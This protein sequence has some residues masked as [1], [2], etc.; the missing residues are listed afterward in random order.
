MNPETNELLQE[1]RESEELYARAFMTNPVAMSITAADSGRFTHI[2]SAFAE[3]VGFLRIEIIG[4]TSEE[5]GFWPDR[6]N[7]EDV[8]IRVEE[9]DTYPLIPAKVRRKDG[10]DISVLVSFRHLP[11]GPA[12]LSVLVPL[13]R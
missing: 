8:A 11:T 13:P 9:G 6:S 2:N 10:I 12:V 4:R 1:L 7:R 5:L 3:L